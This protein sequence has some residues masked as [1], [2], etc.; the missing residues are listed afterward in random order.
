MN[1]GIRLGLQEDREKRSESLGRTAQWH[2]KAAL[3]SLPAY[4]TVQ[5]MRF[6]YKVATQKRAK[7]VRRVLLPFLCIR[8]GEMVTVAYPAPRLCQQPSSGIYSTY[9]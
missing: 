2:G 6:F 3:S 5:L 4:L 9:I 8:P 1:E 7:I